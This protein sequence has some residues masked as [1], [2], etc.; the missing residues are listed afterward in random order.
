MEYRENYS[1]RYIDQWSFLYGSVILDKEYR[2]K[3]YHTFVA[4][5]S[6]KDKG[7]EVVCLLDE[8]L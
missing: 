2:K 8:L 5:S 4:M 3:S 1:I 7:E 6:V